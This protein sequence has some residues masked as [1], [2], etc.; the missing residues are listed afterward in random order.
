MKNRNLK[1][2]LAFGLIYALFL[3]ALLNPL[4]KKF[5]YGAGFPLVIL[6][7]AILPVLFWV[8]RNRKRENAVLEPIFLFL[9][10]GMMLLSW[11]FSEVR[12]VG[13]SEVL[14]FG[15][16]GMFYYLF[17]YKKTENV[18]KYLKMVV[19]ALYL[20]IICGFVLYFLWP[21]TRMIG[22]FFNLLA[23]INQWPN[24]F[25]LFILLSWPLVLWFFRKKWRFLT[26]LG[27]SLVLSALFL[28]YSRGVYI[29]FLGQVVLL[30][31]YFVRNIKWKV[32]LKITAAVVIAAALVLFAN[33][34]RGL[35]FDV[36]YVDERI[37]FEDEGSSFSTGERMDFW[38]GS[39]YLALQKPYLG[40]GPYSFRSAY[41]GI[42]KDFLASSDHSHNLF[43]KIAMENGFLTLGALVLFLGTFAFTVLWRFPLLK[44]EQKEMVFL[45]SV[46]VVGAGAH[47][48][49]DYNFNFLVNLWLLFLLLALIRSQVCAP[50]PTKPQKLGFSFLIV[51]LL[52]LVALYEGVLLTLHYTVYPD[53][54]AYSLY[55]RG[56]FI[57]KAENS[58]TQNDF[59]SALNAVNHQKKLNN[60]DDKAH[61]LEALIA[62]N[63]KNENRDLI[64]CQ[65][66]FLEALKLNPHNNLAY[67]SDYILYFGKDLSRDNETIQ[68]ARELLELY[69]DYVQKN[70]HFTA[71]SD[72]VEHADKLTDRLVPFVDWK[73]AKFYMLK[74]QQMLNKADRIRN[75]IEY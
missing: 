37:G 42:Q 2:S 9:F 66:N 62:C 47:S 34:M 41:N 59:K 6:F 61:Y 73:T 45:L 57:Q 32:V 3:F 23:P 12:N 63:P 68:K 27:F 75:D 8:Y 22:P 60:I 38:Q 28:T 21:Q 46:A 30:G 31:L 58:L 33:Y 70:I 53:S 14:A 19:A 67:Y 65:E 72:N 50:A 1:N 39:F 64:K 18:E 56:Y 69:F 24:A 35:S 26:I 51:I 71:Y 16:S 4:F 44:R 7:L 74:R 48:L 13:L 52:A 55:P 49:I 17:A 5:D 25:G 40:W 15:G 11:I 36:V 54:L 20:A 10:L 43:L 29:A